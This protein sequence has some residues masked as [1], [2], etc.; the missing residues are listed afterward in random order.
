MA[1]FKKIK[2]SKEFLDENPKAYF[3][4]G[5]DL[6][7]SGLTGAAR[8][9]CHPH[10]LSFITRKWANEKDD[11]SFYRPEEYASVFFEELSKLEKI[12]SKYPNRTFYIPKIGSGPSNRFFIWERLIHH[13]LVGALTKYD[14]VVFCW[15]DSLV[16]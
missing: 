2:I 16:S 13:N 9:K 15:E 6:S 1:T 11:G 5:D 7:K 8:I 3:V 4:H 14:N 10:T 12:V